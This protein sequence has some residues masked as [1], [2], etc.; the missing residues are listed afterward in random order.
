MK[1]AWQL[2]A[3][4]KRRKFQKMNTNAVKLCMQMSDNIITLVNPAL[5]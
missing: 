5:F 3:V 1:H 4:L 2:G